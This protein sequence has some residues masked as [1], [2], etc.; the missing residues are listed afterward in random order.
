[1]HIRI[2]FLTVVGTGAMLLSCGKSAPT[3]ES[4]PTYTFADFV[5]FDITERILVRCLPPR[6]LETSEMVLTWEQ[7]LGEPFIDINGNGVYDQY[8]D[9]FIMCACSLNHDLNHNGRHDGPDDPWDPGI[10]FDDINGN[11]TFQPKGAYPNYY[12]PGLPFCDFNRNGV[13]DSV[14][15]YAHCMVKSHKKTDTLG[16]A[17]YRYRHQSSQF[18][19]VSDSGIV[20]SLPDWGYPVGDY[21]RDL[22]MADLVVTDTGLVFRH[23]FLIHVL[24]T[25]IISVVQKEE[26]ILIPDPQAIIGP[27]EPHYVPLVFEKDVLLNQSLDIWGIHYDGLLLVRFVF[28]PGTSP[29]TSPAYHYEFYFSTTEGLVALLYQ[30]YDRTGYYCFGERLPWGVPLLMTR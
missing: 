25:G 7:S 4:E 15:E 23:D 3:G 16:N 30:S 6:S 22:I 26:V 24:D 21:V 27:C 11:G 12:Q 28:P 20:Y 10:P 19:F 17:V 5:H 13:Y 18:V 1:M 2:L 8:I 9:S 14:L 29:D